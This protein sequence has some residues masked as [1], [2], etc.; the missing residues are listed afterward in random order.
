[1]KTAHKDTSSFALLDIKRGRATLAK[2][3]GRGLRTPVVITGY[4]QEGDAGIGRDDGTSR[5][6][7][8][9]VEQVQMGEPVAA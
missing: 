5:E 4:I 9:T 3:C 8:V 7:S 1:M 2:T 6:F